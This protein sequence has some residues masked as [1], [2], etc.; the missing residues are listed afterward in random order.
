M[1]I[2]TQYREAIACEIV[3]LA[4]QLTDSPDPSVK[5]TGKNLYA[6]AFALALPYDCTHQLFNLLSHFVDDQA[7]V[8]R[9][10]YNIDMIL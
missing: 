8:I 3:E 6:I 9:E 4:K 5:M 2:Q 1:N 7:A 10:R